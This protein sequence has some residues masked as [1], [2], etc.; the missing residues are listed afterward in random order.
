MFRRIVRRVESRGMVVNKGK[1]KI[2][3]V[4]DT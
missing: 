2:L 3:C 1:T 4:S